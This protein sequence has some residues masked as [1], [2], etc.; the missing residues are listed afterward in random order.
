MSY[1]ETERQKVIE[2]GRELFNGNTGGV[3]R[4]KER[5]F[6]LL[7]P[8]ENLY[9]DI[10]DKAIQYFK[11]NKIV[12]WPGGQEPSGHMLSSQIACVN[13][14][15]FLRNDKE[16]ALNVLKGIHPDFVEVCPDFE[17]GYIGFEVTSNGSYLNEVAP[18]KQQ[19]RGA[20]CTSVDAMMSGKLRNSKK[21]QVLIEWKYTESYPNSCKAD[22]SSGA[23]RQSR[24]NKLI[25]DPESP[26]KAHVPMEN[27]YYEPI[28]Q[29]MRQTLL[30]WQMVK[31]K[32]RE[33]QADDWIHIDVIPENNK[34][35]RNKV[36]APDLFADDL[37]QSWTSL[38]KEPGKYKMI[39]QQQLLH[40]IFLNKS[41]NKQV[42][43]LDT[44]YWEKQ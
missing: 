13:H 11:E 16:A 34:Q 39:T 43:Y 38:L 40:P 37:H 15:F 18:G 5:N 31:H 26:L 27:F 28:Y 10:R 14:L 42:E 19:T 12:W 33:L 25:Q 6:V 21:I 1:L 7:N 2:L 8:V 17:D 29:L 30:A 24:Y 22:G 35:L 32:K 23:T 36:Y 44:R 3:Y 9:E 41:Y 20:N 4:G